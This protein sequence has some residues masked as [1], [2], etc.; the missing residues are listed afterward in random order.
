MRPNSTFYL[1]L[2]FMD[3]NDDFFFHMCGIVQ[4]FFAYCKYWL[5]LALLGINPLMLE[6][7]QLVAQ[8]HLITTLLCLV[9][10]VSHGREIRFTAE[11][12]STKHLHEV[13]QFRL[14]PYH[15]PYIR[16]E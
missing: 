11:H 5:L 12:L 1:T 15:K 7:I 16:I 10:T 4:R 6:R 9:D 2:V 8:S 14:R 13:L 3:S